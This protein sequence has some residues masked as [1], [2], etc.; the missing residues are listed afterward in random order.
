MSAHSDDAPFDAG[1]CCRCGST[2]TPARTIMMLGIKAPVPQ[3]GWGCMRC[4]LPCD[5]CMAVVCDPCAAA[6]E[7]APDD[8][9]LLT[10]LQTVCYGDMSAG[11]R[12]PVSQ[13]ER[14]PFG[15][16]RAKHPELDDAS[17]DV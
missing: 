10:E 17:P 1:P 7:H 14:E 3:S 2:A 8:S 5:G 6:L 15:H 11:E 12:F 9:D 13:L 16:D 4:G